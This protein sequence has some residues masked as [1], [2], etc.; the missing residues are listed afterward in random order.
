MMNQSTMEK[1]QVDCILYG[2]CKRIHHFQGAGFPGCAR[3]GAG[4]GHHRDE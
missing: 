3:F 1:E 2:T 4:C